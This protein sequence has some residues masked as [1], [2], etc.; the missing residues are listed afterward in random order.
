VLFGD[1]FERGGLTLAGA[2]K[3]DVDLALSRLTVS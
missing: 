1:L 2:G 3:E